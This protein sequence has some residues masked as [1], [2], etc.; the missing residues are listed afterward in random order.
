MKL[1]FTL[2]P[3]MLILVFRIITTHNEK[4]E[5]TSLED[6]MEREHQA[7]FARNKDISNL[8]LFTPDISKLPFSSDNTSSELLKLETKV[9]ESAEKPMLDL[10]TMSNTDIKLEYGNGNF[11]ILSKYDQNYM[12]FTRDLFAWG[13]Y[14]YENNSSTDSRIVL[15][16]LLTLCTDISGAFNILG[17]IYK[18]NDELAKI[19][20]LIEIAENSDSMMKNSICNSLRDI[21]N[22]Y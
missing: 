8:E 3:L 13:K 7:R 2:L 18:E 11:P 6:Y 9:K 17:N 1:F 5:D 22:S 16:Y 20:D 15:E 14:L 4:H 12:Y 21:I 19:S 10:H